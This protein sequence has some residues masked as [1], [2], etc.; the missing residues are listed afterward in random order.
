MYSNMRKLTFEFGSYFVI[1]IRPWCL[2]SILA[3]SHPTCIMYVTSLL[4][5]ASF[6]S[7]ESKYLNF[8]TCGMIFLPFLFPRHIPHLFIKLLCIFVLFLCKRQPFISKVCLQSSSSKLTASLDSLIMRWL[9]YNV[10]GKQ[11][12]WIAKIGRNSN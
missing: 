10:K 8:K 12:G 11:N 1:T 9:N 5:F 3:M 7:M 6:C 2:F 4:I